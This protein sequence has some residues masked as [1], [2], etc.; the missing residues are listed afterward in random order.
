MEPHRDS[1]GLRFYRVLTAPYVYGTP[2]ALGD[3]R[4][5]M[6]LIWYRL[7]LL[8]AIAVRSTTPMQFAA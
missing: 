3:L 8:C 5:A 7:V 1:L 4:Y 2:R 6:A